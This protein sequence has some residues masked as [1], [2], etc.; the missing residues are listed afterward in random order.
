V[1]GK[2]HTRSVLLRG[3]RAEAAALV[4]L[5]NESGALWGFSFNDS[6][7]LGASLEPGLTSVH[8][9]PFSLVIPP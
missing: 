8:T 3:F 7:W 4:L 1:G 9:V 5:S 6:G 2:K